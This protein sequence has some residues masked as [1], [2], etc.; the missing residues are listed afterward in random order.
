MQKKRTSRLQLVSDLHLEFFQD[1]G[2]ALLERTLPWDA[3]A[4]GIVLAGDI[5]VAGRQRRTLEL[6][7]DFFA[8][9]FGSVYYVPGN[10]EFYGCRAAPTLDKIRKMA[11]QYPN[12]TL[13]EPGVIANWGDRRVLGA[14]LWFPYRPECRDL[15]PE[16]SDFQVIRDF[17]PWVY[18]QNRAHVAWLNESVQE[19]DIVVTHHLPSTKSVAP[20]Y[21][22]SPLNVFFV[23]ELDSL[24]HERR[25]ALWIHGHTHDSCR[26]KLGATTVLCNPRGYPDEEN[27]SFSSTTA[28]SSD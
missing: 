5:G 25:P 11:G 23:C 13:L 21:Q 6:A 27:A 7:F 20:R 9:R 17:R 18:E 15:S 3:D 26:Y 12:V 14:T 22:R 10:H 2:R 4:S 8:S 28:W 19:G 24:I 1:R 16:I